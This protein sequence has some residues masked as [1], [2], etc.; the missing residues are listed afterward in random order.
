LLLRLGLPRG[1]SP[2]KLLE[3]VTSWRDKAFANPGSVAHL[4]NIKIPVRV[5]AHRVGNEEIAGRTA[6]LTY[7]AQQQIAI[8]V[9]NADVSRYTAVDGTVQVG[10]LPNIPPQA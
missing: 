8:W 5:H 1:S 2:F 4:A 7:P 10:I 3:R 9:E 6:I